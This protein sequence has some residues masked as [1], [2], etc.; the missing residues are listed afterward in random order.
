M[1]K[2]DA[3]LGGVRKYLVGDKICTAD[4]VAA[5]IIFTF[6]GNKKLEGGALYSDKA[7][8]IVMSKKYASEWVMRLHKDLKPYL[9]SRTQHRI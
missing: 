2:L 6:V 9:E 5:S 7:K 1:S 3:T 4:F 8:E